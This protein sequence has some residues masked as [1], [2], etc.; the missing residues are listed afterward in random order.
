MCD[1]KQLLAILAASEDYDGVPYAATYSFLTRRYEA[2]GREFLAKYELKTGSEAKPGESVN[3]ESDV[4][5]SSAETGRKETRR[6]R[7]A[8][9]L[10]GRVK[11]AL[12]EGL[13]LY[14]LLETNASASMD[15]IKRQFR[16]A[17]LV[18]HPDKK[19]GVK[20][21][22]CKNTAEMTAAEV[23]THFLKIQEA[24]SILSDES[25]RR[26]YDSSSPFDEKLPL[27]SEITAENFYEIC[28]NAFRKEAKW[29]TV[30][31]V[32]DLGN[33]DTA[34]STVKSFYQ[35][36]SEKFSSWRD[37]SDKGEY[38]IE[39]G[40]DREERRWMQKENWKVVSKFVQQ[41][42]QRV[43]K[44]VNLCESKD[45]RILAHR[46]A[47]RDKR[48]LAKKPTTTPLSE[49]KSVDKGLESKRHLAAQAHAAMEKARL[50]RQKSQEVKQTIKDSFKTWCKFYK[51]NQFVE[52]DVNDFVAN[53]PSDLVVKLHTRITKIVPK[54]SSIST[55]DR[56]DVVQDISQAI[57]QTLTEW[58]HSRSRP[59]IG[60]KQL[61]PTVIPEK[62]RFW[63]NQELSALS[64]ALVKFPGGT[65][66]R[67]ENVASSLG[68]TFTVQEVLIQVKKISEGRPKAFEEPKIHEKSTAEWNPTQQAVSQI[69]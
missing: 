19:G 29:S 53:A 51:G 20:E 43:M 47:E 8:V 4:F 35:F 11:K 45:P 65:S 2:A 67:W 6:M 60:H 55:Q 57:R 1:S 41:E 38:D 18:F 3:P 42:H 36:W 54:S 9:G 16:K 50:E 37:F 10:S 21:W 12:E 30:K 59:I 15:D 14:G 7:N 5:S 63:T 33:A 49:T 17:A 22:N 39:E 26:Q 28:G 46:L 52:D 25:L 23:N 58:N 44:F 48:K 69:E 40:Q 64:K 13:D 68:P 24:A 61:A 62:E 32:P 56:P 31:P 27:V 66:S 34:I